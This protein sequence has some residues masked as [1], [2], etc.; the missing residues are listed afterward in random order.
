M[1]K[2]HQ[3]TIE[4]CLCGACARTYYNMRSRRIIR[5]DPYQVT[6]ESCDCCLVRMGFDYLITRLSNVQKRNFSRI[7]T[8]ESEAANG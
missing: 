6:K 1:L 2:K 3:E 7:R 5:K 8:L 4:L